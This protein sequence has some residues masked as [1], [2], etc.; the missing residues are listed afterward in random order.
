MKLNWW[1]IT[2]LAGVQCASIAL[3]ADDTATNSDADNINTLEQQIHDLDQKVRILERQRELDKDD[4]AATAKNQPLVKLDENG[5]TFN[6]ADKNFSIG[7]HG[8]LQLDSRT[9]FEN[10]APG[11]DGF[12]LRRARPIISGTVYHDF[13][14]VFMPDFGGSSPV[15]QDAYVNYH[16]RP[17]LQFEAGKFKTPVGLE[18]LQSTKNWAFNELSLASDLVPNRDLGVELHGDLLGGTISYAAGIFNGVADS[19]NTAN[20]DFDNDKEFAGRL[21]FQPLITTDITALQGLGFGVSGSYGDE[22]GASAVNKYKTDGQQTWFSYRSTVSGDGERWRISPQGYYYYGPFGVLA[23]YVQSSEKV[24]AGANTATLNNRAWD[25]T[26]SW[27]LTGE[28]NQYNNNLSPNNPFNPA[29]GHWGALGLFAR[30]AQLDIDSDAFPLFADPTTS[31]KSADAWSVGLSWWLNKNIRV[32][33]DFSRTTF[34]GGN[35]GAVTKDPEEVF[36]TRIQL[37]F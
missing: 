30:Y 16:F 7:L 26:A 12:V 36:F 33:T 37:A 18:Y 9:F 29:K 28:K 14:Y 24:A 4:A 21:F 3:A 23:E 17:E 2:T 13:D 8:V 27:I 22:T 5:F 25:V 35:S 1:L 6:S 10:A 20:S 11:V 32:N 31:A 15:I 19:A 34:S